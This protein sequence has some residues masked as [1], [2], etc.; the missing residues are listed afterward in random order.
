MSKKVI[1]TL[2]YSKDFTQ[3]NNSLFNDYKILSIFEIN[4]YLTCLYIFKILHNLLVI[5]NQSTKNNLRYEVAN[6]RIT[7]ANH[8]FII[9]PLLIKNKLFNKNCLFLCTIKMECTSDIYKDYK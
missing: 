1:N 7:R 9:K 4:S 3:K 2:Y 5:P 8:D 6:N